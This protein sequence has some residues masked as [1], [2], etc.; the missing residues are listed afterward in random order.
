MCYGWM[1]GL[2][3]GLFAVVLLF[4]GWVGLAVDICGLS[5]LWFCFASCC[6]VEK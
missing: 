3:C 6:V 2:I 1:F 4:A 5:W